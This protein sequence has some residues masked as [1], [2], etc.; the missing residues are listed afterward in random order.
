MNTYRL[1][2]GRMF[3]VL[4]GNILVER[5]ALPRTYKDSNIIINREK[6]DATAIGIVRA[7]SHLWSKKG[8]KP[9][10]IDG[11]EPGLKVAFL[12]FYAERHTNRQVQQCLGENLVL[13]KWQDI[14]LVWD[15]KIRD[16]EISDIVS[17]GV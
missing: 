6:E 14:S 1:P 8:Q 12:W 3:R 4:N 2:D 11:I 16:Y 17:N 15:P 13:L 10:P 7:V 5:I 9:V